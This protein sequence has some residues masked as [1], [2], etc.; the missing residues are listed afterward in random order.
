M[1]ERSQQAGVQQHRGA[2]RGAELAAYQVVEPHVRVPFEERDLVAGREAFACHRTQYAPA[3]MDKVNAYLKKH[4]AGP[5]TI[6]T[7]GPK[8]LKLP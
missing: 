1:I 3:E 4:K 5:F 8:E 6:V 2:E 7:V